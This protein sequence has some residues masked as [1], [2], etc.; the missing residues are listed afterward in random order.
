VEDERRQE[1]DGAEA[2]SRHRNEWHVAM[3]AQA[4]PPKPWRR[5]VL[6]ALVF[7]SIV[8]KTDARPSVSSS[9]SSA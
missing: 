2:E 5:R 6:Q 8:V 4:C 7:T 1:A 3:L 9:G